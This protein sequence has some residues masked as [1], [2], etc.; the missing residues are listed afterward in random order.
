MH[1]D[2][3]VGNL[4][5]TDFQ[6]LHH[7]VLRTLADEPT[8]SMW[9]TLHVI[10]HQKIFQMQ[11]TWS[12]SC[13]QQNH[14]KMKETLKPERHKCACCR[15]SIEREW[16]QSNRDHDP[17]FSQVVSVIPTEW[18]LCMWACLSVQRLCAAFCDMHLI[19]TPELW[20]SN[21]PPQ[22]GVTISLQKEKAKWFESSMHPHLLQ[23]IKCPNFFGTCISVLMHF[24]QMYDG[25]IDWKSPLTISYETSGEDHGFGFS[26]VPKSSKMVI[27]NMSGLSRF[28]SVAKCWWKCLIL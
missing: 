6:F 14:G 5:A 1:R 4:M 17:R 7:Q 23:M 19:Q 22:N 9:W 20:C 10:R 26:N 3:A 18:E 16:E 8:A 2:P 11:P 27:L 12:Q 15:C 25:E 24:C 28:R 21:K 13:P